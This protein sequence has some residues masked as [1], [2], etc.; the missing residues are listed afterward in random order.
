MRVYKMF[1]Y[2][3]DTASFFKLQ[4]LR[5][6]GFICRNYHYNI[7]AWSMKSCIKTVFFSIT[8]TQC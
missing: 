2:Y 4:L 7:M 6:V 8:T 3:K 1:I 5:Y